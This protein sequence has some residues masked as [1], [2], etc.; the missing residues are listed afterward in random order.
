MSNT[1]AATYLCGGIFLLTLVTCGKATNASSTPIFNNSSASLCPS[2]Y[3]QISNDPEGD[4]GG[5][6]RRGDKRFLASFGVGFA[7]P[8]LSPDRAAQVYSATPPAY[9]IVRGLG[10]AM[11]EN[12]CF[13]FTFDAP[14]YIERYN[15]EM[16]RLIDG[17]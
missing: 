7:A 2:Y 10:D 12:S 5:H 11:D 1:R 15:R 17:G 13:Q 8:G 4:A 9:R 6:F 14:A 3:A 16:V